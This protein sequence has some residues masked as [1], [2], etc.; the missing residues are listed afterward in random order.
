MPPVLV[1]P[2][3][4]SESGYLEVEEVLDPQEHLVELPDELYLRELYWLDLKDENAILGF[5]Y[6][7]GTLVMPEK[8]L[9]ALPVVPDLSDTLR[10][11]EPS[12]LR[13]ANARQY[14]LS[15]AA[16]RAKQ[17]GLLQGLVKLR[18]STTEHV[19]D[20]N[21]D[22]VSSEVQ[23]RLEA[24]DNEWL[25]SHPLS[26]KLDL[27]RTCHI[28]EFRQAARL[29]RDMVRLRLYLQEGELELTAL[30]SSWESEIPVRGQ[31]RDY[32]QPIEAA[33]VLAEAM[34]PALEPFHARVEL[35][36]G[37][38]ARAIVGAPKASTFECLALQLANHIAEKAAYRT[39]ENSSC[40][41][42]FVRQRGRST[43]GRHRN[44]GIR[45]CS[46]SCARAAA[47]RSYR[48][49]K[50]QKGDLK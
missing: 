33:A 20:V 38:G 12:A 34:N 43:K 14:A 28:E 22:Y 18:Q 46:A 23:P 49:S 37:D 39:C 26:G 21:Q 17:G 27:E 24:G 3:S 40:E 10:G 4:L 5:A 6:N 41:R 9:F 44:V 36:V 19:L 1:L 30:Q 11:M 29:I 48:E 32:P 45:Y 35:Q 8:L 15:A 16:L 2:V 47:Q 7:Y 13:E 42:Y 25:V 31:S 50:K